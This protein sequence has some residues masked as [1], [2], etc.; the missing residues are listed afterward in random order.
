[1]QGWRG[2]GIERLPLVPEGP[3]K[4]SSSAHLWQGGSCVLL[5]SSWGQG[6]LPTL[7]FG[8]KSQE[9]VS[10]M[11]EESLKEAEGASRNI[12]HWGKG[13]RRCNKAG[14]GQRVAWTHAGGGK[15]CR[16]CIGAQNAVVPKTDNQVDRRRL[17]RSRFGLLQGYIFLLIKAVYL[18]QA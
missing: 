17:Q 2:G 8:E 15:S 16:G 3:W 13:R 12:K 14:E 18:S 7:H 6:L 4:E 11:S 1:M 10:S 5:T 9:W